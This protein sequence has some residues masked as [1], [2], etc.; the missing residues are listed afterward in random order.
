M[1]AEIDKQNIRAAIIMS[2]LSQDRDHTLMERL[3]DVA[4][5]YP[6]HLVIMGGGF[7]LNSI[8]CDA[9]ISGKVSVEMRK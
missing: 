3:L 6:G 1:I 9:L 7:L 4:Q 5:K 2:P 8:I